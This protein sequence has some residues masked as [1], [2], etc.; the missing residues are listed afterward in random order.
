MR[1]KRIHA[2][3]VL[4]ACVTKNARQ[5]GESCGGGACCVK[6]F[7]TPSETPSRPIPFPRIPL[8]RLLA[9]ATFR[10]SSSA[11]ST[12]HSVQR[13]YK[14][15]PSGS[16]RRFFHEIFHEAGVLTGLVE[17][18]L[19]SDIVR[20]ACAEYT[21]GSLA[22]LGGVLKGRP[23]DGELRAAGLERVDTSTRFDEV[24]H[25][26]VYQFRDKDKILH[27]YSIMDD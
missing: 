7:T 12:V 4:T 9:R 13:A 26:A 15:P 17:D 14:D 2:L 1:L 16:S 10:P 5:K 19:M 6:Q 22:V 11:S 23:T 24:N 27:M 8:G 25:P 3:L 18:T 21:D 20:Q